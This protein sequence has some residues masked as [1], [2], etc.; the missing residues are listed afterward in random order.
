MFFEHGKYLFI[1]RDLLALDDAAINL[2]NLSLGMDDITLD[3][4]TEL[5]CRNRSHPRRRSNQAG[6]GSTG[7]FCPRRPRAITSARYGQGDTLRLRQ[8]SMMLASKAKDRLP[9]IVRVP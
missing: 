1:V 9:T 4:L 6:A 7:A 3:L 2:V 5:F 8:V